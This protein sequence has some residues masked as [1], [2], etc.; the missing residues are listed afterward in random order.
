M[1]TEN[2]ENAA[3]ISLLKFEFGKLLFKE[4]FE[5]R[6]SKCFTKSESFTVKK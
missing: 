3:A 5:I 2:S 4:N 1:V 6:F